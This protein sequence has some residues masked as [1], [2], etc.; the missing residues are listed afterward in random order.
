MKTKASVVAMSHLNDFNNDEIYNHISFVQFLIFHLDGD[1][2][3]EIDPDEMWKRFSES[4][5]Y[6]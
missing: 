5:N 3:Q 1:L 4:P 6:V 2:T